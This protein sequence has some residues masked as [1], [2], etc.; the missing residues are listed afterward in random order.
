MKRWTVIASSVVFATVAI[1]SM[2]V[3]GVSQTRTQGN[4]P[5]I[6][7][8]T[9]ALENALKRTIERIEKLEEVSKAQD[10]QIAT[11][12]KTVADQT[13]TIK[14]LDERLTKAEKKIDKPG[15]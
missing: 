12:N 14:K 11:L 4:P 2:S 5:V 15:D 9:I 7:D 6:M 3:Q 8:R 13:A 10:K 1:W